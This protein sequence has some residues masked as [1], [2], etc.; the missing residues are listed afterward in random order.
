MVVASSIRL[1][2]PELYALASIL[3][4]VVATGLLAGWRLYR[5]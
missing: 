4:A 1:G 2:A 5:A 3:V